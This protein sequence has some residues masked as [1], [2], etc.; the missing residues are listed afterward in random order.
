[1]RTLWHFTLRNAIDVF[2]DA[3]L[4]PQRAFVHSL[5]TRSLSHNSTYTNS[6]F[7][8]SFFLTFADFFPQAHH[9]D[10]SWFSIVQR[11]VYFI[12]YIM[13]TYFWMLVWCYHTISYGKSIFLVLRICLP[14]EFGYGLTHVDCTVCI[15]A[16]HIFLRIFLSVRVRVHKKIVKTTTMYTHNYA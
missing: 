12:V 9:S 7:C 16:W 6:F 2:L 11:Y 10:L 4:M 13:S 1:M 5:C 15:F 14:F 3:R 8:C